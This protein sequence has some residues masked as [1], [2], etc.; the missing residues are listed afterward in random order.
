MYLSDVAF[1]VTVNAVYGEG[2][3][4]IM[5]G[6]DREVVSRK[7]VRGMEVF[8]VGGREENEYVIR[9]EL[10]EKE[11]FSYSVFI[12]TMQRLSKIT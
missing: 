1:N 10:K 4:T 12:T 7:V 5:K 2:E 3:V 11:Q 9:V 8:S 6:V